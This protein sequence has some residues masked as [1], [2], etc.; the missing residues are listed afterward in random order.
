MQMTSW[1]AKYLRLG[2]CSVAVYFPFPTAKRNF[3]IIIAGALA[4]G[5]RKSLAHTHTHT[6]R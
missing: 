4:H 1:P 5:V 6:L 2:A 3:P